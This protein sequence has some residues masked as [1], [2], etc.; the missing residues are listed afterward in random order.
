MNL[1]TEVAMSVDEL[2]EQRQ[3]PVVL[4]VDSYAENVGR[5]LSYDRHQVATS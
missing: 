3:L 5:S 2:D 4:A 1:Y